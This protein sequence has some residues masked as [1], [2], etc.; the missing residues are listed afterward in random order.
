MCQKACVQGII[1][2]KEKAS[3]FFYPNCSDY[4]CEK[5]AFVCP[6]NAKL[7]MNHPKRSLAFQLKDDEELLESTSGGA[8]AAICDYVFSQNGVVYGASFNET[9]Q[10]VHKIA[11]SKMQIR[12]MQ[13]SKYV[14]SDFTSNIEAIKDYIDS[15]RLV[16][17]VGLPCQ[18]AALYSYV[19]KET[20]NLIT[21]DLICNGVPSYKL[22]RAYLSY[23]EK[24]HNIEIIDYKFRDKHKYGLSH[25]VVVKYIKNGQKHEKTY[26]YR[27]EI[28]YYEAFGKLSC[29]NDC[30]YQCKYTNLNRVGDFTLGGFW[31][32]DEL[33]TKLDPI[34][35]VGLVLVNTKVAENII[36]NIESICNIEEYPLDKATRHNPALFKSV[37]VKNKEEQIFQMLESEGYELTAKKYF[38]AKSRIHNILIGLPPIMALCKFIRRHERGK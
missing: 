1:T 30:C 13:G 5:C 8:F 34:K 27:N 23:I 28:T 31:A 22:W 11:L 25:T 35:G 38:P 3:G 6:Q 14:L 26:K 20:S 24:K 16:F 2:M 33:P 17:V 15:G 29:F 37:E 9:L 32:I 18:I 21:A 36:N 4:E 19:G 10:V 7:N 12:E